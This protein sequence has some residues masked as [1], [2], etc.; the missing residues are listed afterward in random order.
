MEPL[1]GKRFTLLQAT[2]RDDPKFKSTGEV[3][4]YAK[5]TFLRTYESIS[6]GVVADRYDGPAV[7][8][9]VPSNPGIAMEGVGEVSCAAVAVATAA[10]IAKG[11]TE[12]HRGPPSGGKDFDRRVPYE[13]A[14]PPSG[15][16]DFV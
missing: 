3:P 5:P 11:N 4:D 7:I 8:M 6:G 16:K 14:G 13:R 10:C 9:E 2:D 12:T 1:Q 15:V